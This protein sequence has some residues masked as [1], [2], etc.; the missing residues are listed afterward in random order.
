MKRIKIFFKKYFNRLKLAF[1]IFRCPYNM[2]CELKSSEDGKPVFVIYLY[3][4]VKDEKLQKE[5]LFSA[6]LQKSEVLH[7]KSRRN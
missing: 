3:K 4:I 6:S 1:D 7:R 2:G 5:A